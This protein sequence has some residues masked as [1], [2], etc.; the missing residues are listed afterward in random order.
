VTVQ[1]GA[2]RAEMHVD[3]LAVGD[4]IRIP[5]ALG[6]NWQTAVDP[7]VVSFDVVWSGPITRRVTVPNGSLGNQYAGDY[8]ENQ[9]TVIWS[10]SNRATGFTFTSNPGDFATTVPGRAFAELGHEGNGS[11]FD[12]GST[13]AQRAAAFALPAPPANPAATGPTLPAPL[14]RAGQP[15][16]G[17]VGNGRAVQPAPRSDGLAARAAHAQVVDHVF[18]DLDGSTL[19]A[20][21]G[22]N[23]GRAGDL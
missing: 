19:G 3:N 23:E 12:S 7:A 4:Q 13:D 6:P 5:I 21:F 17:T 15:A 1:F 11:F 18:A 9:A 16:A 8:V 10:G 20:Q 22:D 2:G 14:R